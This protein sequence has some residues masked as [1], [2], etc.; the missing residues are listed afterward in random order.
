MGIDLTLAIKAS[1]DSL[2]QNQQ[3]KGKKIVIF[4][5]NQ[6]GEEI[7]D[8]LNT[9]KIQVE[10]FVDN[11]EK[12][13]GT[14]KKGKNIYS[15]EH[16]LRPFKR[17][18]VILIASKYYP[19][20]V[21]QLEAMG[22]R[23]HEHIIKMAEF[24]GHSNNSLSEEE[25]DKRL[26]EV[27]TGEKCYLEI[28][29]QFLNI[30]KIFVCPVKILGD[31][32]LAASCLHE[33]IR[34]NNIKNYVIVVISKA[35]YKI[36]KLFGFDNI[37]QVDA[38]D[39]EGLIQYSVF[40]EK[41]TD[42]VVILHHRIPYT[43]KIG[44]IGNYKDVN[45]T[46]QFRYSIFGLDEGTL[47]EIPQGHRYDEKS[48]E[49]VDAFFEEHHLQKQRT[50]ILIPYANTVSN[51][52]TEL[53]EEIVRFL[54]E[55]GYDVCTNCDGELQPPIRGTK[56]VFFDLNYCIELLETAGVL[57]SVRCGLCDVLATANCKKIILYPERMYGT[58]TF[59]KFFGLKNMQ[60]CD[61]ANEFVWDGNI[62]CMVNNIR[63][64]VE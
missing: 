49:Y 42:E 32:Y 23:E 58:D 22:Y 38:F 59:L 53:W 14:K 44:D 25:F 18:V 48:K 56:A 54:H 9:R 37:R 63:K 47:P 5:C 40:S 27:R 13:I 33:Y 45:F 52:S 51:L 24:N 10:A 50:A 39:V 36:V 2:I 28:K 8:Y 57:I 61:D 46:D 55:K 43:C 6:A 34:N 64:I 11:S 4:G 29:K 31:T 7:L 1:T 15:P 30:E 20:M 16:Y 60:L 12:K 3:L 19:E 62:E 35:C 21:L 26:V 41:V 17:D